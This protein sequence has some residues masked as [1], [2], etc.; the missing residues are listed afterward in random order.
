M[1]TYSGIL[2]TKCVQFRDEEQFIDVRLKV[3]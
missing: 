2:L 3:G 1:D